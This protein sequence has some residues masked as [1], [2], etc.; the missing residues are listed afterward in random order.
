MHSKVFSLFD[1]INMGNLKEYLVYAAFCI[2]VSTVLLLS[3]T[4][5]QRKGLYACLPMLDRGYR[6]LISMTPPRSWTSEK[7]VPANVPPPADYRGTFPPS[8]RKALA[9]AAESL[10]PE[11]RTRLKGLAVDD[12]E[13]KGG[14]IPFTA[15]YQECGPSMYTPTAVSVEELKAL[16]DFP[17]YA[18]LS[19]VPL[20]TAYK[21]FDIHKALP[22]PYR[23]FRWAYHQTMCRSIYS[24]HDPR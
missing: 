20:P 6:I 8:T 3:L 18:K 19:G 9:I 2:L 13:F 12:I 15:N 16:G 4:R 1:T 23:P 11:R 5:Q 17:D 14:I 10:S 24:N 21:E 22:R 7:K